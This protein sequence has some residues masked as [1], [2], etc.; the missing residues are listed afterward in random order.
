LLAGAIATG[1][2]AVHW[3][4]LAHTSSNTATRAMMAKQSLNE[5][6]YFEGRNVTIEYRWAE[7]QYAN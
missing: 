1:A 7:G 3:P 4:N 5:A 2:P 6:G